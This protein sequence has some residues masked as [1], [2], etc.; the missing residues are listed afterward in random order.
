[1]A[2]ARG[3]LA[4]L[5]VGWWGGGLSLYAAALLAGGR[6]GLVCLS[7]CH[8]LWMV[9]GAS[10]VPSPYGGGVSPLPPSSLGSLRSDPIV[11]E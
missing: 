3:V 1:M 7:C 5:L 10:L 9:G 6:G 2:P 11:Q 8:P 4:A